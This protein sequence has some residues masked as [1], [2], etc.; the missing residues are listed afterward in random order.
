MRQPNGQWLCELRQMGV[1]RID[2]DPIASSLLM[3]N[4]KGL[5]NPNAPENPKKGLI[6]L[7]AGIEIYEVA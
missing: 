5:F 6:G 2:I 4:I 1:K 3:D 7:V